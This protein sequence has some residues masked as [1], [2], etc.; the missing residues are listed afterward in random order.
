MEQNALRTVISVVEENSLFPK[1]MSWSLQLDPG[2]FLLSG[3][4][5]NWQTPVAFPKWKIHF[6]INCYPQFPDHV[7]S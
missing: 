5:F 4:V 6:S 3:L 7:L 1:E 2:F